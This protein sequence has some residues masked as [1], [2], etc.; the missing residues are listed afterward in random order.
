MF[1]W[2]VEDVNNVRLVLFGLHVVEVRFTKRHQWFLDTSIDGIV[3]GDCP[4]KRPVRI[5]VVKDGRIAFQIRDGV[6]GTVSTGK[7]TK[8]DLQHLSKGVRVLG[9]VFHVGG[10]PME[11]EPDTTPPRFR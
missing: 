3:K 2:W 8:D 7:T 10:P 9:S 5:L 4:S 6:A 11:C 1:E